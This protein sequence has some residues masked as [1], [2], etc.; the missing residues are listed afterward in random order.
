VSDIISNGVDSTQID[1]GGGDILI[2]VGIQ[3]SDLN[4]QRGLITL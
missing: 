3:S 4:I 2:F 1:F